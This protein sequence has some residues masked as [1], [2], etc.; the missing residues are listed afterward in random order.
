M[1]F[2]Q[3][4]TQGIF[5]SHIG[6]VSENGPGIGRSRDPSNLQ[7]L[8]V[9]SMQVTKLNICKLYYKMN[10]LHRVENALTKVG[11]SDII[12]KPQ[13]VQCFEYLLEAI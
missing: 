3:P 13:Q 10:A 11:L 4:R 8:G 6:A 12:L 2:S 1:P 9:F 5:A 7:Y